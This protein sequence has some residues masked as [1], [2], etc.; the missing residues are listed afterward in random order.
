MALVFR[1]ACLSVSDVGVGEADAT[2]RVLFALKWINEPFI[3][4]PTNWPPL[5]F[6]IYGLS[7]I[8]FKDPLYV[9]IIVN[10][11]F[12]SVLV[13]VVGHFVRRLTGDSLT[14]LLAA[15]IVCFYPL[16]VRFS[17]IATPEVILNFFLF[18]TLFI[19]I[20]I[21]RDDVQKNQLGRAV[22]ATTTM[23]AAA[24]THLQAWYLMPIFS[25]L[26]WKRWRYWLLFVGISLIPMISLYLYLHGLSDS[27][28]P[29]EWNTYSYD[30][31]NRIRQT[32]YYPALLIDTLSP[33]LIL[34]GAV[35]LI[36]IWEDD[37]PR[38]T[39][40]YFPLICFLALIPPYLYF[41]YAWDRMRPKEALLL[42]LFLVPYVSIG[43]RF[44]SSTAR[45]GFGKW[46]IILTSILMVVVL[47]YNWK[48]ISKGNIFPIPKTSPEYRQI[49]QWISKNI[50]A[51][52]PI[53]FD[54]LPLWSDYYLAAASRRYPQ[55]MF[56]AKDIFNVELTQ[57]LQR[58]FSEKHPGLL[59]LSKTPTTVSKAIELR[60]NP[61]ECPQDAVD[62]ALKVQLK[63]AYETE[64]VVLYR[65]QKLD[66]SDTRPK[67]D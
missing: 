41:V 3:F 21:S 52:D 8:V 5:Q 37:G 18:L 20:G 32:L 4:P 59:V 26:L 7:I 31:T 63:K 14:G 25:L 13:I 61:K 22:L 29:P 56:L 23:T 40:K 17:L 38:L 1:L 42:C 2:A 6:Y 66:D 65:I 54:H 58:F 28:V 39:I 33:A 9:P 43:L 57:R 53:V 11:I 55:E 47:P 64:N 16:A 48:F 36:R 35:G 10:I 60:C 30:S 15:A 45:S 34:L 44:V 49:A 51:K 46:G 50:D 62:T 27:T 12:G 24:L 19:L 67:G